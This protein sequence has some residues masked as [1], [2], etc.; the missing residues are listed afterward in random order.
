MPWQSRAYSLMVSVAR[1]SQ[2]HAT[3]IRLSFHSSSQLWRC[4]WNPPV[5]SL[6]VV[7]SLAWG[8]FFPSTCRTFVC[9]FLN[10]TLLAFLVVLFSVLSNVCIQNSGPGAFSDLIL[11]LFLCASLAVPAAAWKLV[12]Q[13]TRCPLTSCSWTTMIPCPG[14]AVS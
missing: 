2:C 12:T 14:A 8:T 10:R 13:L 6:L 4:F 9:Q 1:V 11:P 5:S 3:L 7:L